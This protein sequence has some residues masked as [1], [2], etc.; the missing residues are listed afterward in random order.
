MRL[1]VNNSWPGGNLSGIDNYNSGVN[2]VEQ[3]SRND[4]TSPDLIIIFMGINDLGCGVDIS[5]F[6]ADYEKT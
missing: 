1:C 5:L 3:L 2:R 6:S 4:G